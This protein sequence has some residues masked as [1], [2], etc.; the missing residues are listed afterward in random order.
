M[1]GYQVVATPF[2]IHHPVDCRKVHFARVAMDSM[3]PNSDG[4]D[5]ESCDTVLMDGCQFNTG[6][7]CIAI[8]AGKANDTQYGPTRNVVLHCGW[9]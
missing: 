3:G 9:R 4:F 8:K 5:P 2:W 7:D 6:D 1:Q